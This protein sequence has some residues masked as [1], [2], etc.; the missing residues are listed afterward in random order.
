M[1]LLVFVL[2][3]V[4]AP[5]SAQHLYRCVDYSGGV[6]IQDKPCAASAR[7]TKRVAVDAY[8][9]TATSRAARAAAVQRAQAAREVGSFRPASE[10]VRRSSSRPMPWAPD[11]QSNSACASAKRYRDTVLNASGLNRTFELLR[12]LDDAVYEACKR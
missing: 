7:E 5:A 11:S 8:E 4:S 6:S 9:E 2:L 1:R 3:A 12:S 10:A